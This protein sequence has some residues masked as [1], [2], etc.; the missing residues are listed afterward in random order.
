[1]SRTNELLSKLPDVEYVRKELAKN[2]RERELLRKL[3]KIAEERSA[4]GR[5]AD[6]QKCEVRDE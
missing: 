2:L 4:I 1:M 3:L 6:S 5:L